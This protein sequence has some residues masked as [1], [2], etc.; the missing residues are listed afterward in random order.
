M[1]E[2]V[3]RTITIRSE[4]QRHIWY[5]YTGN[6]ESGTFSCLPSFCARESEANM[7]L[8][9]DAIRVAGGGSS[10]AGLANSV[11]EMLSSRQFGGLQG[12]FELFAKSGLGNVVSSWV[13]TGPNLPIS[14]D[15]VRGALGV[16][17]LHQLA[18]KSGMTPDSLSSA[19][20]Q[21]LPT[22]VDRLTP[23]GKIPEG[24]GLLN[25]GMNMLKGLI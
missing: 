17:T 19:L 20:S 22:L 6:L 12:L 10:Q 18:Q 24:G 7:G 21:L 3:G 15:Q 23:D 5:P 8:L 9:D 25:Q 4:P 13:G 1:R 2:M 16:D 14:G 11:M